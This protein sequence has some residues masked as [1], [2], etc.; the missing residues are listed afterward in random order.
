ALYPCHAYSLLPYEV[1]QHLADQPQVTPSH[2][3]LARVTPLAAWRLVRVEVALV[4]LHARELAAAGGGE[5]LLRTAMALDLG[6]GGMP[7]RAKC[8]RQLYRLVRPLTRRG[9][10]RCGGR[11]TH[12]RRRRRGRRLRRNGGAPRPRRGYR[13]RRRGR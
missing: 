1:R 13:H 7:P 8:E 3:R 5:S 2:E 10:R 11:R 12:R 6:H 4:G 9:A